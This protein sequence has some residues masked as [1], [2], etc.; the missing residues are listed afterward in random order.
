MT[1]RLLP[2]GIT[3]VFPW[4]SAFRLRALRPWL[5]AW[6]LLIGVAIA[7]TTLVARYIANEHKTAATELLKQ[8]VR[9]RVNTYG[10]QVEDLTERIDQMGRR[11]IAEWRRHPVHPDVDSL[12]AGINPKGKPLLVSI[13]DPEAR[14]AVNSFR[15]LSD[16]LI[17]PAFIEHHRANCCDG[18]Q[19]TPVEFSPAIGSYVIQLSHRID[20]SD[21]A[22]AGVLCVGMTPD[23]LTAFEDDSIFGPSD[24]VS[25]RLLDGPI[26]TAKYAARQAPRNLYKAYPRFTAPHGVRREPGEHFTDGV[27]RWVAWRKHPAMPL[28]AVA[29]IAEDDAMVAVESATDIYYGAAAVIIFV[30][31]L[32]YVGAFIAVAKLAGRREA[33]EEIR[34]VYR[35]ATDAANEGFYMLRPVWDANG[36]LID[37]RFEDVNVCGAFL[38]AQERSQLL[39]CPAGTAL[40]P[41]VF[42]DLRELV[43]RALDCQMAED[44]RRI[45]AEAKLPSKWL[46]RRAVRVGTGVALTLRDISDTKA[47]EEELLH[48]AHRD[49]LTG[50]PNRL[51]LHRYLPTALRRARRANKQLAVL[52]V[53]LDHFKTVNDTLGHDIGDDLLKQVTEQLRATLRASDHVVRLGGDEFLVVIEKVDDAEIV[54]ALA[55]KLISSLNARVADLETPL[56]MVS[57]SIGIS[58]YPRDGEQP[59]ALLKHADIA[60]YQAKKQ[61]RSQH[62][63]YTPELSSQLNE[64][65]RIEQALR[66]ALEHDELDLY[67]QPKYHARSGQL[68]GAEALLRWQHPELGM[69]MPASFVGLAENTGL[70][71]Q[72]GERVIR[73][74][75]AQMAAWQR[76]GLPLVSVAINVSPE[77]LRRADVATFLAEQLDL[78]QIAAGQIDIEITESAMVEQTDAVQAQLVRLR[79]LGVRLVIDDFGAGYS[80][81]SQLQRLDADVLKMDRGLVSRLVPGSDAES[82]CRG[83]IWMASALG[84]Q[85]VAEGVETPE[86]LQVLRKIGC[87]ELQGYLLSQPLTAGGLG[88]ALRE[89]RL[90]PAA[91]FQAAEP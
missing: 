36:G 29:A 16:R 54:D 52:F 51:W 25:V 1:C 85:V 75:V 76:A 59:D 49:T 53:D 28:I 18:W 10:Q 38:L 37:F 2:D 5:V 41:P 4:W 43:Q 31:L 17:K 73:Q 56:N 48:L 72:I 22:F 33:D 70:I 79:A 62:Y 15:P 32:L 86:Q 39:S 64:R 20:D 19:V 57:A 45:A 14:L 74:A 67:Y 42:N 47:H 55:R 26:L 87:D 65:L 24:F 23:F 40:L 12:L 61:G 44:E 9:A 7:A 91:Q 77:Q 27:T 50:L 11:M 69:V 21:G 82:L 30:L 66:T 6:S 46:F 3:K 81:L 35:A 78:Y 8:R 34:A 68:S 71:V 84:L 88:Q 80:S 90:L 89:S 58:L 13:Y 63:W 60:M 83:I